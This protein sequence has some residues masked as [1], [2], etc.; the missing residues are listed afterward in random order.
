MKARIFATLVVVTLL[1]AACSSSKSDTSSTKTSTSSGGSTTTTQP[2]TRTTTGVTDT[3]INVS[4]LGYSASYG[5]ALIGAQARF[6]RE[7]DAGG[8]DGR[9]IIL[10]KFN[11]ENQTPATDLSVAKQV[12]T[13]D[14][15]FAIVPV[16]TA[17]FPAAD[18]L[19]Q[20]GVPYVGW[21]IVPDWCNKNTGFSLTGC[22]DPNINTKVG[23]FV[24]IV[25]KI[26]PDKSAK[27]K[28][29]ALI[30]AD[31][32]SAKQ[33]LTNF[34]NMWRYN[35]AKVVYNQGSMPLPPTVVA[36]YT[37]Y[38]QALLTSNN[39][40]A[41][42]LI[43]AVSSFADGA[44]L[45]KKLHELNY[46]GKI[47]EFSLYDP[48]VAAISK[49]VYNEITFAPWQSTNVPAVQ[50]MITDVNAIDSKVAHSL[51]VEAGYVSADLFIQILKKVGKDL[52][53]ERFVQV[54]N[55]NF[56][57][58]A[59]GLS[60]DVTFP[61]DHTEG[62]AGISIVLGNGTSYDVIA[63]LQE[64]SA[65]PKSVLDAWVKQHPA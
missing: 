65:F 33:S 7:N 30:G 17:A 20:Q 58:D 52:T 26:F 36:D 44:G 13:Q 43:E 54:A 23:N 31:N 16:M 2:T 61:E 15:P 64:L 37:P 12:V 5:D 9:K 21:G 46:T 41:P 4:A 56:K 35:G 60:S 57:Y 6:K 32:D 27:G 62:N 10:T 3:T 11:D 25:E 39:G 49:N 47:L 50:Q 42:D 14:K 38:A 24:K 40:K 8:V 19:N 51:P 34:G 63:P 45:A 29:I 28:T 55:D 22:T 18:Y 59:Q 48:R 1:A 53:R